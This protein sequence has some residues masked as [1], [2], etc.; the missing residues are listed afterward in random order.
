MRRAVHLKSSGSVASF[1]KLGNKIQNKMG[2]PIIVPRASRRRG[3]FT[4]WGSSKMW[5]G[6]VV[7]GWRRRV[8]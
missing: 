8:E 7:R 4:A 2:P 5:T 3:V 6:S 1:G